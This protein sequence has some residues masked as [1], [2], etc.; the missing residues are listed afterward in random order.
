MGYENMSLET[1]YQQLTFDTC[2]VNVEEWANTVLLEISEIIEEYDE[3]S[4]STRDL[5][6]SLEAIKD[7]LRTPAW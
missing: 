2:P 7:T 3:G 4:G 5:V 6:K 1:T